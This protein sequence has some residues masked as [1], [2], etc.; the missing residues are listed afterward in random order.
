MLRCCNKQAE[1]SGFTVA[2]TVPVSHRI[3][4]YTTRWNNGVYHLSGD[5]YSGLFLIDKGKGGIMQPV[6]RSDLFCGMDFFISRNDFPGLM[7]WIFSTYKTD[8]KKGVVGYFTW[9]SL[10]E[11]FILGAN[12]EV[13]PKMNLKM[14]GWSLCL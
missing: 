3:P 12:K 10:G 8:N 4:F 11:R 13:T 1:Q 7:G 5:K 6:L 9:L 2:G 14:F